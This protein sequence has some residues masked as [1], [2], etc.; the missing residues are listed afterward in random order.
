M[1][2]TIYDSGT[3]QVTMSGSVDDPTVRL[4]EGYALLEG[5][6]YGEGWI[7]TERNH[8]PLPPAPDSLHVFNWSTK[9]WEDPRTLQDLKD[10]KWEEVK[11][12][13]EAATVAPLLVTRFGVFDGDA[14][15][16]DNIKSTVLGLR[17]AAEIGA[18]PATVTWT[19]N[20]N[21]T[22]DLTP[23]EFGE[24]AAMLLARGDAAHQRARVLRELITAAGTKEEIEAITWDTSVG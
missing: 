1:K 21:S 18:A 14:A 2:Y 3:G 7:D 19:L 6:D 23:V 4:R 12:W 10:A 5:E 15:G 24:V 20:D 9:V 8:H 22:V 16:M 13:R 17:E 11:R